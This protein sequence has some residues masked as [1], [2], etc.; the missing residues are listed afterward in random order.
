MRVRLLTYD[1]NLEIPFAIARGT[2]SV[3]RICVAEIDC[4]GVKGYGE[5][6]F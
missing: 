6:L 3:R 1:L 5:A 4:D 2:T